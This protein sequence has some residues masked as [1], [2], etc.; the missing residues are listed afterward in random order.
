[1]MP[2]TSSTQQPQRNLLGAATPPS[3]RGHSRNEHSHTCT[4]LDAS[5]DHSNVQKGC[6][7]STTPRL[8]PS[9]LTPSGVTASG[10]G[11]NLE[12]FECIV[13][14]LLVYRTSNLTNSSFVTRSSASSSLSIVSAA[15]WYT[16]IKRSKSPVRTT[17]FP[18]I[19]FSSSP[20]GNA[21]FI[22]D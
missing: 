17:V 11:V 15:L 12:A 18:K 21:S 2:G 1:M 20:I 7:E 22:S 8:V 10:C 9:G 6:G 16:S 5:S 14:L 19:P 3:I 13:Y 4:R